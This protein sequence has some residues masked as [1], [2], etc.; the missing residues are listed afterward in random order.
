M[1]FGVVPLQDALGAILAHTR[2]LGD[3][4]LKKG[5]TL[6]VQD[7]KALAAAGIGEIM[8]ARLDP[9][10]VDEDKAANRVAAA[11]LGPGLSRTSAFTGRSN[12]IA[13]H[14]GVL[15]IDR[16]RLD[17]L[18]AVDETITIATL[19]P[20]DTVEPRQMVATIKV[21]LFAV[22]ESAVAEAARIA[23]EDPAPALRIAP[24][25]PRPTVLIQTRIEGMK[26]SVL[27]KTVEVT[28]ARLA[29]LGTSLG[30]DA[31]CA[32]TI[33]AVT[34]AIRDALARKAE[35]ILINGASANIDRRDVLPAAIAAAGGMV[36]QV[37]MPV[38]PG[39]LILTGRIG[40]VQV[41]GLPGCARSPKLNGFDWVLQRLIADLPV[42]RAEIMRMGVGGLLKEIPSRPLPRAEAQTSRPR[43]PRAPR[44]AVIVLTGGMSR[45]MGRAN[46]LLAEIGGTPMVARVVDAVLASR[47]R[48]VVVVTGHQADDLR[49]ALAGRGVAFAHNP[50]FAAGLSGTLKAGLACLPED[51]D[52]VLVCLGDMPRVKGDHLDRLI[53]AFNPA[54]GRALCVP[55]ANGKRGNP[56]LFARRFFGAMAEAQGDIGARALIADNAELVVEVAMED[57]GVLIDVDEP[58]A[59]SAIRATHGAAPV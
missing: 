44:I 36:E 45:R 54:E 4:S 12:L 13:E 41:I 35:L 58:Q 16:A 7:L 19:A 8:V 37:G 24:F 56:V 22:A 18:N 14:A 38:D 48:P 42:G 49:A 17:R 34:A 5:R 47:A 53:A 23:R 28:R 15:V 31:R 27:D 57:D 1:K 33:E 25:R 52:G 55:T 40:P 30:G 50:E 43:V 2:K 3:V 26:E 11:C 20:F 51:C 39:N 59:L 29:E 9:D 6:S 10:D 21:I 46:K 32:H